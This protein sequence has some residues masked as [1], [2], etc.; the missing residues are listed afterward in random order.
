MADLPTGTITFLFTDIEGST[1]RWEHQR[2]SMQTALARHDAILRQAIEAHGGYVFKTMG[3][4]FCAAFADPVAALSAGLVA[5]RALIDEDWGALGSVRVRMALHTGVAH[6]RNGDYFGPPLNRVARLLSAGHGG[7]VLVSA[8][9]QELVRDQLAAGGE[10]RD[11]GDHRLKDLIR[12][13]HV[14]QLVAPNLPADFP[15]LRTLDNRPNNLPLQP[16][17]FIGRDQ[18]V[19]AVRQ[20]LLQPEVR[21]LTLTGVGG[22]GKTRLGLQVAADLLDDFHDGVFFV[23]LAPITDPDLIPSTIAATLGIREAERQSLLD[24]LHAY[25]RTRQLLLLLDNFEHVLAAAPAVAALLG[26]A[27]QLKLLVTSRA[28][29]RVQGEHEFPVPPLALPDPRRLPPLEVLSQYAAVRLFIQRAQEVKPD[30]AVTNTNA[31]A[32]AEICVRLDGLPLAIELAAARS[33]FLPPAALLQ[34][35]SSRLKLL[36]GGARDLPMRQQTL[37]AAIDWSYSLLAVAEQTLFARLSVFA[38]GCTLEAVEAVCNAEGDVAIDAFEGVASLLDKS[39][40]RQAEGV[41]GEPRFTMLQT[42]LE[43]A[44]ERLAAHGNVDAIRQRHA[45]S[46]LSL[47]ELAEPELKGPDTLVWLERLE[48]EHDNLHAALTWALEQEQHELALRLVGALGGFWE[49]HGRMSEARQWLERALAHGR[50]DGTVSAAA[51]A[52]ALGWLGYFTESPA[53]A[54]VLKEESV[55]LWLEVGDKSRIAMGLIGLGIAAADAGDFAAAR[56]Y[57]EEALALFRASGNPAL[58]A[59][60]LNNLGW[61]LV[62][63]GEAAE[64]Q[65]FLEEAVAM[66]REVGDRLNI[67]G[68]Q[69]SLSMAVLAQGDASRAAALLTESLTLFWEAGRTTGCTFCLRGLAQVAVVQQQP[70]RAARLLGAEAA[71][72]EALDVTLRGGQRSAYDRTVSGARAQLDDATWRAAWAAGRAMSLE[73]A[74]SYGLQERN[75]SGSPGDS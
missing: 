11:L 33:K 20:R 13:E 32:V 12:P 9:T 43:Y 62:Q 19:E 27:P 61:H 67:G 29:L 52:L 56:A 44:S 69:H 3:D 47:V 48:A 6:E 40:L 8:A 30:F 21:L 23:N 64:A 68:F 31:P 71:L 5:Q 65:P 2:E 17:P 25:L 22:T 75:E 14:F 42:I 46:F 15:P 7:Q 4:A 57:D 38:G 28:P 74:V 49:R 60:A 70:E 55:V 41:E 39:L 18:A 16:N 24:A 45:T 36:T 54:R 63:Q 53:E 10:L 72:R 26:A 50:H 51:R 59:N 1:S 35:L 34:R 66:I 58:T 37:R 73:Q